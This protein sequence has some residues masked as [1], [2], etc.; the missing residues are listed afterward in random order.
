VRKRNNIEY[1]VD[2]LMD[3]CHCGASPILYHEEHANDERWIAECTE[4]AE[5]SDWQSEKYLAV[6][7]WN[8]LQRKFADGRGKEDT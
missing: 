7:T 5:T 3:R 4:C 2:G 6:I 8:K 1:N